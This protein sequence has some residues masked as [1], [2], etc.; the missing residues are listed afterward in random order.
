MA[1]G[2]VVRHGVQLGDGARHDQVVAQEAGLD[3]RQDER[4]GAELEVRRDLAEVGVTDDDVETPVLRGVGVRLVAGV[5]DR[6]LQGGLEPD[7]DLEV[8]RALAQLEAVL[9]TLL[10]DARPA[11]CRPP[12]GG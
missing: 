10:P 12:P 1:Q 6:P 9:V 3:H 7:L 11:R 4:G 5:D 8:V 2:R